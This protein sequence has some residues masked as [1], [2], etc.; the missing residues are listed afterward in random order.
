MV[1]GALSSKGF[2][3]SVISGNVNSEK[4]CKIIDEFMPY[5]NALFPNG[6]ILQQDWAKA[7]TSNYTQTWFSEHG[8]QKLQWPAN[9]PDLSP[10]EN[11]WTFMKNDIEKSSP[12]SKLD[13]EGK[14]RR[15]AGR[16]SR[17]IQ[18]NLVNSLPKRFQLCIE[19]CGQVINY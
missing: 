12:S 16:I 18:L 10:I 5:A 6:W 1:W 9:S 7:H 15:A 4:Y 13:L 2:Y 14:I 11:L 17:E 19:A 3:I 8:V